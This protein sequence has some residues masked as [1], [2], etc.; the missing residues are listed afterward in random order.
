MQ[1][2]TSI[3]QY[4]AIMRA[5]N[6][7]G[8]ANSWLVG[9]SKSGEIAY[10]ELGLRH[11]PLTRKSDGYFVSS[12]FSADPGVI[13]DD[14][15]GFDPANK[16]SSMNARHIRAEDFMQQHKGQLDTAL[17]EAFLSDH[18][19]T[20]TGKQTPDQR[21]LC[22]HTD[23]AKEGEPV[24][25]EKPF[26]PMGAVTG[27]VMDSTLAEKMSFT[28]RAGHPCGGDF[29]VAPFLAEHPE[30]AW[31]KSILN[32]MDASPWTTFITAEAAAR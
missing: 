10:L 26:A 29:K 9:D 30:Y 19:D 18:L 32:D 23:L 22:G 25:D 14:T 28:A 8:Y 20:F 1:Y 4:A 31:Q 6:N 13:R 7:G 11:T 16:S 12:N 15:P 3:D 17:A 24:W 21:S 2:A 27:K 5:G